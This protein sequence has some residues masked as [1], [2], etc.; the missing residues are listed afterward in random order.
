MAD[1]PE[2]NQAD[3]EIIET[4]GTGSYGA[5]YKAKEKATGKV[6][7]LKAVNLE[8]GENLEDA[9][10]E[11]RVLKDCDSQQITRYFNCYRQGLNKLFITM[12]LC[13]LGSVMSI[14]Q[15]KKMVGYP[16]PVI[17]Y[18]V[19]GILRGLAYLH[20]HHK[21]HRDIKGGNILVNSK[22]EVKLADFG[23]TA[24]LNAT[25]GRRNTFIGSPY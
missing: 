8:E 11:I 7:A 2:F 17:A 12:E 15:K 4:M 21:L 5:V 22:G 24:M 19:D 10:V 23:I 18:I 20:S 13:E 3:Y 1:I 25:W 14:L 16:E 6:L 9:L